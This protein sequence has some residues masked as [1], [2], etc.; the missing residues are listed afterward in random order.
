MSLQ[1]H[2]W[3]MGCKLVGVKK[4]ERIIAFN[5]L[6]W[7]ADPWLSMSLQIHGLQ[8]LCRS[9]A[10]IWAANWLVLKTSRESLLSI[11]FNV[12]ADQWLA[13]SL[14]IHGWHMCCKLVKNKQRIM[15]SIA[16]NVLQIDMGCKQ[17][18][19]L[20]QLSNPWL[21]RSLQIHGWHMV[22]THWSVLK[23]SENHGFQ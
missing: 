23:H 9:M 20:K 18:W 12:F 15:A 22:F 8:C 3:H 19:V 11:A 1:I 4:E 16:C 5:S 6:Q 17:V 13:M 10:G 14:Q 2:G 21:S 7:L